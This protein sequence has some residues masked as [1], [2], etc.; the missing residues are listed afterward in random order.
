MN[1]SRRSR[2]YQLASV[3]GGIAVILVLAVALEWSLLA[4]SDDE[5][6]VPGRTGKPPIQEDRAV[7]EETFEL[8][9]LES[10]SEMVVDT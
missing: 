8:P 1:V 2:E 5:G 3:L 7:A 6:S 4:R 10:Y 9:G